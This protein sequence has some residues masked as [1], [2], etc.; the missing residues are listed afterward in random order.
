VSE[1]RPTE[2]DTQLDVTR[3]QS[4]AVRRVARLELGDLL[5]GEARR[6]ITRVLGRDEVVAAIGELPERGVFGHYFIE[7]TLGEGGMARVSLAHTADGARCVIKT[8]HRTVRELP[9]VVA[10]FREEMRVAPRLDHPH[11]V[12]ALDVGVIDGVDYI[13][14]ELVDGPSL[15]TLL[16]EYPGTLP[17]SVALEVVRDVAL[18]LAY[19]HALTDDDGRPLML[20]HRDVSPENILLSTEGGAR[21]ADFGIARHAGRE[22]QTLVGEVKG[23][24]GY[25][26][27]E[28]RSGGPIDARADLYALGVVLEELIAGHEVPRYVT[29]LLELLLAEEPSRRPSDATSVADALEALRQMVSGPTLA[30]FLGRLGARTASSGSVSGSDPLEALG[31]LAPQH[32]TTMEDAPASPEALALGAPAAISAVDSGGTQPAE[33]WRPSPPEVWRPSPPTT[34]EVSAGD[35]E[36]VAPRTS[37]EVS[38]AAPED[39]R[40]VVVR[41]PALEAEAPS[42]SFGRWAV[43]IAL[44][45]AGGAVV[46]AV[47]VLKD[48]L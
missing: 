46:L 8:I 43:A 20:V 36:Q 42:S 32:D 19:A 44:L 7:S 24:P 31:S 29:S 23:K 33:V 39:P 40:T 5:S 18:A 41:S 34:L 27:P 2:V 38:G 11:V 17:L 30:R 48:V 1:D 10:M 6:E 9:E 21:L 25:M 35:V 13:A 22:H 4:Q 47:L 15:R 45:L 12:R 26:A 28:Q 3:A 16:D 14:L 37:V